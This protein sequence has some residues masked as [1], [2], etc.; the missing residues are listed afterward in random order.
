MKLTKIASVCMFASAVMCSPHSFAVN[1]VAQNEAA[2][3]EAV[4]AGKTI[5]RSAA[6]SQRRIDDMSSQIQS[7]LQQFKT[8]NKEIDG[9]QVYNQQMQRQ[10]DNQLAEMAEINKSIDSVSVIERQILPLMIRMVDTLEQFIALDVPFLPEERS[11]RVADLRDMLDRADV[12][13]SEKFR[14]IL[15]AY[16]VEV[17]FGRDIEAY[18]GIQMV[19]GQERDVDFLRIGRIALIYQTRDGSIMGVWD[20]DSRQWLPLDDS[21]RTPVKKALRIARKQLAP[22]LLTIPVPAAD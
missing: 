19:D 5:N 3:Q 10:I 14:R 7:K 15:E 2:L 8:V 17:Q 6:D 22:D 13:T 16:E 1:N 12:E 20:Q 4:E 9:L 11:N 21:Y 18:S